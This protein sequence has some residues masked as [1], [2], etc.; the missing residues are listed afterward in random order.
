[1]SLLPGR[2]QEWKGRCLREEEGRS[3]FFMP[4]VPRLVAAFFFTWWL[5]RGDASE[6]P[7][8]WQPY[9]KWKMI[10]KITY[11][12]K[13]SHIY[14][15]KIDG[16]GEAGLVATRAPDA[17][18]RIPGQLVEKNI[19]Y[20]ITVYWQMDNPHKMYCWRVLRR[21]VIVI[22]SKWLLL[23]W[24]CPMAAGFSGE[25]RS[26]AIDPWLGINA[27]GRLRLTI[28]A[29]IRKRP[30]GDT[31]WLLDR[32]SNHCSSRMPRS[33]RRCWLTHPCLQ[34]QLSVV[35]EAHHKSLHNDLQLYLAYDHLLHWGTAT[36]WSPQCILPIKMVDN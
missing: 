28:S 27:I 11:W 24:R 22:S 36:L 15:S 23:F 9:W 2:Q 19:S 32:M 7:V 30:T 1:M 4:M 17:D 8:I 3:A 35:D 33:Q 18:L 29:I 13:S 26:F 34:A 14:H 21:V 25:G 10:S 20:S 5:L 6:Y 16:E 31:A 12:G